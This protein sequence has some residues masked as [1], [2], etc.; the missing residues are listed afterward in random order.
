MWEITMNVKSLFV[1]LVGVLCLSFAPLA[2]NTVYATING[3]LGSGYFSTGNL[4]WCH[5]GS[6]YAAESQNA[7]NRWSVDTDLNLSTN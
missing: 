4:R 2:S 6:Q 5:V 1:A 3:Y 7:V